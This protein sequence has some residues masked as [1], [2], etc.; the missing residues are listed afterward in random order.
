MSG[1]G[2]SSFSEV[3]QTSEVIVTCGPG[4]VGKTTSAAAIGLAAARAGRRAVVVTVDPARRL[5]DA[6]GVGDL[7]NSPRLVAPPPGLG[8]PGQLWAMMLDTQSTFDQLVAA[9]AADDAQAEAILTNPLYRHL[10]GTLSG[11][12][13]YMATEKL[14]EL[15]T[16]GRFDVVVVDTPPSRDAL[17]LLD[18]PRRLVRFLEHPLFRVLTAPGRTMARAVG[19]ASRSFLW[20]VRRLAGP[21]IVTDVL[22]LFQSFDGMEEGFRRRA[23][24]V[25][26]ELRAP[27]TSFVLITSPRAEALAEASFLGEALGE[28]G[29]ALGGLVV[30]LLHPLPGP[31]DDPPAAPAG[32]ALEDHLR[33]HAE[34]RS[35]GLAE[36]AEAAS[37]AEHLGEVAVVEVEMLETDVHDLDGLAVVAAALCPGCE[38]VAAGG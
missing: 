7:D 15:S 21:Q 3:V 25:G 5:A 10:A 36:R 23:D 31:V 26:A 32:S 22:E 37:V 29:F 11:T 24:E 12:Q 8:W 4:G 1:P 17:E 33:A 20:S 13:E 6:L 14:H 38:A 30:N 9:Q 16:S 18:A 35:L 27:T 19:V 28:Q 34:L 2:R